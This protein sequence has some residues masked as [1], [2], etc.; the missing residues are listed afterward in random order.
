MKFYVMLFTF[1][2][3]GRNMTN[4]FVKTAGH[5]KSMTVTIVISTITVSGIVSGQRRTDPD[6]VKV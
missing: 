2:A 5:A 4:F 6:S 3:D 1:T